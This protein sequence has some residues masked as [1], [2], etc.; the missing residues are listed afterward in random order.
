MQINRVGVL[1]VQCT[2]S[3]RAPRCYNAVGLCSACTPP[4]NNSRSHTHA[5][6]HAVHVTRTSTDVEDKDIVGRTH[7]H[8][9]IRT[10]ATHSHGASTLRTCTCVHVW[11]VL[12]RKPKH[13]WRS[14]S[15]IDAKNETAAHCRCTR[16]R[17]KIKQTS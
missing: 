3:V 9:R 16:M 6:S 14:T 17:S 12:S 13:E 4:E 10:H 2:H 15:T 11:V 1:A 5:R 7:A 8:R